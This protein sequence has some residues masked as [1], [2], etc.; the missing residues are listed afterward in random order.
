MPDPHQGPTP[1]GDRVLMPAMLD[2]QI[3]TVGRISQ[4]NVSRGPSHFDDLPSVD[5]SRSEAI[6]AA[7]EAVSRPDGL[8]FRANVLKAAR[9]DGRWNPEYIVQTVV[10]GVEDGDEADPT[11]Y[12]VDAHT[13]RLHED[14]PE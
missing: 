2:V 1:A 8:E 14:P 10:K 9:R 5:V 7:E 6:G 3:N 11:D 4:V 13:G 12:F